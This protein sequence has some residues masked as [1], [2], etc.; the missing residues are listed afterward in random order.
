MGMDR[1]KIAARIGEHLAFLQEMGIR[2]IR[3]PKGK[4]ARQGPGKIEGLEEIRIDLGDCTRCPLHQGRKQIVFG[5]GNSSADL[6]FVGEGPGRD[7]DLQGRPFVGRAGQLLDRILQA[8]GLR[9][10]EVYIANMVKC[11][12]PGNRVPQK[13]EIDTCVPFLMRQLQAI[14]PRIV[15]TM[16]SVASQTLLEIQTPISRIRGKFHERHGLLILP[17]F[18]PAYLLRNPEKKR[19][20]WIDMKVILAKLGLEPPSRKSGIGSQ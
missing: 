10:E 20:V 13:T 17:T 5:E 4:A 7:E 6:V 16:G 8:M 9:R 15:C 1:A 2:E 11:R 19:E 14:R 12:P 18:H 3:V